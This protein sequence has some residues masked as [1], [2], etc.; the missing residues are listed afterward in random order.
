MQGRNLDVAKTFFEEACLEGLL[1]VVFAVNDEEGFD[2]LGILAGEEL[3]EVIDIAVSA[4]AADA[5]YFG[6]DFMEDAEDMD[7]FGA[8]HQAAA[9]R[10]GFAIPYH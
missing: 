9:Q 8:G 4:H 3:A 1:Y 10:M 5:A 7:F 2:F 6:V